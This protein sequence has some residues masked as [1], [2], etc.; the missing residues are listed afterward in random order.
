MIT[1]FL[2]GLT[3]TIGTFVLSL[4]YA[5]LMLYNKEQFEKFFLKLADEDKREHV[6]AGE[7]YVSARHQD[8]VNSDGN[9]AED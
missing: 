5:F 4:V 9:K 1:K 3:T 6:G 2:G 8:Q 7:R